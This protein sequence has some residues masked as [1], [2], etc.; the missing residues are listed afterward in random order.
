MWAVNQRRFTVEAVNPSGKAPAP[1]AKAGLEAGRALFVPDFL[2]TIGD[3][4]YENRREGQCLIVG[5]QPVDH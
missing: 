3:L 1:V 2:N 5:E 4:G